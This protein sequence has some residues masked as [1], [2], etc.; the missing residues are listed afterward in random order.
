M[1]AA[2]HAQ[3]PSRAKQ[4]PI[5]A[6]GRPL[7]ALLLLASLSHQ[8]AACHLPPAARLPAQ[9]ANAAQLGPPAPLASTAAAWPLDPILLALFRWQL[10]QRIGANPSPAGG[11]DGMVAELRAYQRTHSISEQAGCS[12]DILDACCGPLPALWRT[13]FSRF[14]WSPAALAFFA[15]YFLHFLVG[16]ME[17]T[18]RDHDDPRPGGV[19]VKRC[20]VLEQSGCK[21][22]CVTMCKVPTEQ[23]FARRWGVPLTLRPNF[24]TCECQLSFG[25]APPPFEE[26]PS[27]P[28]GCL[29]NCPAAQADRAASAAC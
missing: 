24:E 11:F 19:R 3:R 13:A 25:V 10:Q 14:E 28:L 9:A 23:H 4:E 26:D 1:S 8:L 2:P 15:P 12:E 18:Q 29:Q 17:T 7:R 21:G 6:T 20:A 22:L 27:L 5:R 16:D